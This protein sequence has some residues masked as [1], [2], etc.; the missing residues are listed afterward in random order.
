MDRH[1]IV[2]DPDSS[3]WTFCNAKVEKSLEILIDEAEVLLEYTVGEEDW[4][5]RHV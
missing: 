5:I 2:L 1:S 3:Q 4:T